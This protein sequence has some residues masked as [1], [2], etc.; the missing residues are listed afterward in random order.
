[1]YNMA[2]VCTGRLSSRSS[3]L[4]LICV[5][6][7]HDRIVPQ[8][9]TPPLSFL[10]Y[11]LATAWALHVN[12]RTWDILTPRKNKFDYSLFQICLLLLLESSLRSQKG[13][14]TVWTP[15]PHYKQFFGQQKVSFHRKFY[16][17][18]GNFFSKMVFF[19]P[20]K[21]CFWSVKIHPVVALISTLL[22]IFGG[23]EF[24]TSVVLRLA[25]MCRPVKS[26][27]EIQPF[28]KSVN[29]TRWPP[30]P[31]VWKRLDFYFGENMNI[32]WWLQGDFRVN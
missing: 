22:T 17:E 24:W 16:F 14:Q 15:R 31:L 5:L 26:M 30:S 19:L 27:W 32:L 3:Y 13:L 6:F 11:L 1:M 25:F 18:K 10:F 8:A 2:C 28:W 20:K 29:F 9:Y 23:L 12:N 4:I 21:P 7:G